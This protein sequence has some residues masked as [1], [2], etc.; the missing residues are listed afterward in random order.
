MD[1]LSVLRD[2]KAHGLVAS[3]RA[4]E[5]RRALAHDWERKRSHILEAAKGLGVTD[6]DALAA[7]GLALGTGVS[8]KRGGR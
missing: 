5:S 6:A 1:V 3:M 8:R 4:G 2:V 7:F